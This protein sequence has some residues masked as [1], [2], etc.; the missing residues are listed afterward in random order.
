MKSILFIQR[1]V[2]QN[3]LDDG[4]LRKQVDLSA[5]RKNLQIKLT[6]IN[7]NRDKKIP[8][9]DTK[10]SDYLRF[11]QNASVSADLVVIKS[12]YPNN[13]IKSA[14]EL[15][16]LKQTYQQLV[17]AFL[18]NSNGK[19]LI[20]TTPPLRP[21]KTNRDEASRARIL[22]TWLAKQPFGN[23]VKVFNFYD[24]LAEPVGH[25][26]CNTLKKKYRRFVLWD[27]HPNRQASRSTSTKLAHVILSSLV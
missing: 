26:N 5:R 19:L 14:S 22:A 9:T 17:S 20:M 3:L 16:N 7:N 1:S 12:C 27:N 18:E 6:D 11:F 8:G 13:A 24:L 15:S 2:G 23:R 25:K 21:T 10:P 4:N